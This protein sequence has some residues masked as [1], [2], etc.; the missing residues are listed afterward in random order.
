VKQDS[1][2]LELQSLTAVGFALPSDPLLASQ[3]NLNNT[4]QTGGL[5]GIDI[6][7][8]S[9]W[10]DYRGSGV[11]VGIIDDGVEHDHPDLIANYNSAIDNDSRGR[12]ADAMAEGSD[13]HGTAVAGVIAADDNG[14]GSVGVAPDAEIAGF[15]MGFGANGTLGQITENL[16]LQVNV[17][18]S[19]NSWG[20]GGFFGDN[21]KSGAFRAHSNAIDDTVANGRDGLGTVWVFAAGNSRGSGD[22]VNYH[23]FQNSRKTIAV[24][25]AEDDGDIT[26]YS[27]PGAAVITTAPVAAGGGIGGV[28]TTDRQGSA[29]YSSGF[30]GGDFAPGFNGTSAATPM[31]SGVIA[32][33]LEANPDLGY[34][35]VQEILA[36]SSRQI[37][38]TDTGW[39]ENGA[40]D[41]NGGG[42]HVS[43]DFGFG[44]ID[45]HAAVRLAESWER[46]ST[47]ANE[48]VVSAF[49]APNLAIV[50]NATVTDSITITDPVDLQWVEV[51]INIDHSYIGDLV[52]TLTSPDGTISTLVNRPGKSGSNTW[53]TS[54]DDINFVLTSARHWGED[55]TGTWTLS[56][57]DHFAAD[58]GTLF[59]W[60][61]SLYGDALSSNNDYVYTDEYGLFAGGDASRLVLSDS[62]GEDRINAAA[63]SAG[64]EI[65]LAAGS[66]G[67]I[68]GQSF[69]IAAG[70]L[71]EDAIGGDGADTLTGNAADNDLIGARGD[72]V[73]S[74]GTGD[75][76]L[77][78]GTGVDRFVYATGDGTDVLT[79]FDALADVL[80]LDGIAGIGGLIDFLA[81]GRSSETGFEV[82][83]QDGG[84]LSFSGLDANSLTDDN[85]E[86]LNIPV[87]EPEP[88]PEPDPEPTGPL[89]FRGGENADQIQGTAFNDTISGEAGA[90]NI[91]GGDG[92][93]SLLGD[94]GSDT[95]DGGNGSDTVR[96][97]SDSDLLYGGGGNDTLLGQ[98]GDDR[99]LG[100]LQNDRLAGGDGADSVLGESGDDILTGDEGQDTLRGGAGADSAHGG[101]DNDTL[102]GD[103][104]NDYLSG[105]DGADRLAGGDGEDSLLGGTGL[106]VITG[107][108][109]HDT[110]RAGADAD[111][112]Y[113]GDGN[114]II[115]GDDGDDFTSGDAGDDRL[116]GGGGQDSIHGGEGID[117]ITG[118]SG[119][120]TLRGGDDNDRL[121]GGDD[122]DIVLGDLGNDLLHGDGG[123][124]RLVGG[125]GADTLRGGTGNDLITGGDGADRFEYSSADGAAS[126][127]TITDFVVGEDGLLLFGL[128]VS[129]LEETDFRSD[130]VIDTRVVFDDGTTV[131]LLGVSGI[132]EADLF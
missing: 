16:Q 8:F 42:L 107:G 54:Q 109:G 53:G 40:L 58:A 5:P 41:W 104:G 97:G 102:L 100:G 7:V 2:E 26:F 62:G 68:A 69:A 126:F 88:E 105:N 43:H 106:D 4:G 60:S 89:D 52:V 12:D 120:D 48:Q 131:D 50:D 51:D 22:D 96:G 67:A 73:I 130:G 80:V 78:G 117:V 19:N 49:R 35:D 55:A 81:A 115:F 57:S 10:D 34:R 132:A 47:A 92:E 77:T 75:D 71:I 127:D 44:L 83:F 103:G 99:L 116:L 29:G 125:S 45:A 65:N 3:F 90:D 37:D 21:F 32:L 31:V 87:S 74:G 11:T 72:D 6:N 63:L 20:F 93:D 108:N 66:S 13:A 113:G 76:T 111:R 128:S 114:D 14:F 56:I 25:A 95:I 15:R 70:T 112:S 129:S 17:D 64:A 85:L 84:S 79:D 30:E 118:E 121:Y 38:A 36:Y 18:I 91:G 61:L 123:N 33:I 82:A 28:I 94:A 27:T 101:A 59:T 24:A 110:I 122:D 23:S 124:D 9:V 39:S 98:A 119:R 1:P 86:L 46:Q